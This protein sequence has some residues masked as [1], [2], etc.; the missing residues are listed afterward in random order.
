MSTLQKQPSINL[1]S[2]PSSDVE[3]FLRQEN[4]L[5]YADIGRHVNLSR[6][7]IRQIFSSR[8][9]L[10]FKKIKSK[11]VK[12]RYLNSRITKH[13]WRKISFVDTKYDYYV[14]DTG[15]V[16]RDVKRKRHGVIFTERKLLKP[17]ANKMGHMRV[18]LTLSTGQHKTFYLH[19]IV[20]NQWLSKPN[21]NRRLKG[22]GFHDGDLSN[23]KKE[24]LYWSYFD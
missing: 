15:M 23:C 14:S 19:Q 4:L 7:R 21:E 18:N 16:S 24:N 3:K 8:K 12:E 10:D 17:S 5:T 1:N 9:D 20:A 11:I 13:N 2:A 6:E 22:V